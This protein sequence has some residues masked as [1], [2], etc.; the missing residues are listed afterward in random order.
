MPVI[1]I[2]QSL[3]RF[4][5]DVPSGSTGIRLSPIACERMQ[6]NLSY[7][8]VGD[9]EASTGWSVK[10]VEL[11]GEFSLEELGCPLGGRMEF[12]FEEFIA[13]EANPIR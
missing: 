7:H 10:A 5:M 3:R 2:C 1:S 13:I 11:P 9:P 4:F 8:S 6:V 12:G